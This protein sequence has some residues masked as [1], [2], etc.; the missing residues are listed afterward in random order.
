LGL[1]G[2]KGVGPGIG[3]LAFADVR[4]CAIAVLLFGV[5]FAA[6]R[7]YQLSGLT[8]IVVL[9][10]IAVALRADRAELLGVLGTVAIVLLAHREDL[11]EAFFQRGDAFADPR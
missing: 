10:L 2:G 1:R 7:R 8:S 5:L 6:T 11:R 9:P 3:A 4:L